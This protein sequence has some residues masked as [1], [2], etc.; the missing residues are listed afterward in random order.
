MV[1]FNNDGIIRPKGPWRWWVCMHYNDISENTTH[2]A[3]TVPSKVT[4]TIVKWTVYKNEL[5]SGSGG[6]SLV[7]CGDT[8]PSLNTFSSAGLTWGW[9]FRDVI[10]LITPSWQHCISIKEQLQTRR[11]SMIMVSP[12]QQ[13]NL[14]L[15]SSYRLSDQIRA[16]RHGWPLVF[17]Q[18]AARQSIR[19]STY[20]PEIHGEHRVSVG[21]HASRH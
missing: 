15:M 9:S 6:G 20:R 4:L 2:S 17:S 18:M 19:W 16:K 11:I 12:L 1:A 3:R 8:M 5:R 21:S 7:W 13:I 10:A 14:N